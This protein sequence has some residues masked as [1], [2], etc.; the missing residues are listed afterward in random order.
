MNNE[1]ECPCGRMEPG[2]NGKVAR[3]LFSVCCK[4]FIQGDTKPDY[5]EQLMRSRYSAYTLGDADYLIQTWHPSKQ[6]LLNR[7]DLLQSAKETEWLSL[8][9][10]KNDQEGSF[11]TVEFNAFYR[12]RRSDNNAGHTNDKSISCMHEVSRFEKIADQWYYFDGELDANNQIKVG[13]NDPCPCGSG[14]K[15]KKCCDR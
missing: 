13:R 14:K 6:A 2:A 5:C 11:G 4:P 1:I 8:D 7:N 3:K 10:V 9:V 12:Q 15:Y